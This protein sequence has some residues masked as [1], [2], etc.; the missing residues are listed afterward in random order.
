MSKS[1]GYCAVNQLDRPYV[2]LKARLLRLLTP[3]PTDMCLKLIHGGE[4][5][6]RRP[7][8]LMETM[9]AQLAPGEEDGILFKTLFMTKLPREVRSH[10]LARGM[11][12][13]SRDMAYLV[14]NLWCGMFER[15]SGAKSHHVAAAVT[16]DDDELEGTVA[17]L[18][19]QPKQLQPKK[20]KAPKPGKPPAPGPAAAASAPKGTH[21]CLLY[22]VD[23]ASSKRYLVDSGSAFSILPHK[24][25]AEPTGLRLMTAYGK[26]LHCWGRR[27]CSVRTR[28]RE[29]S[30]MFLLAPV[31]FP[32]FANV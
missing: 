10:V 13:S 18:N 30:W 11:N 31:A 15:H 1:V 12:H 32:L 20:K 22:Q 19:V 6:N 24:S 7:T 4:I 26:P 25:S 17:A 14:D 9:L 29:F 16:E 23:V 27:T 2:D 5:G 8:Q 28:T 3:K 21:S